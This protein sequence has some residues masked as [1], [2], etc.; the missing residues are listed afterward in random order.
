MTESVDGTIP[1]PAKKK[2]KTKSN[3]KSGDK[4]W[5]DFNIK[6]GKKAEAV[7][8]AV[9]KENLQKSEDRI[10][11]L[12]KERR[13]IMADLATIVPEG[14]KA[15]KRR[16]ADHKEKEDRNMD[17]EED[18]LASLLADSQESIFEEICEK[19]SQIESERKYLQHHRATVDR[20][21]AERETSP[22]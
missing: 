18:S 9:E 15:V 5:K 4:E 6:N 16:L 20:Y 21:I 3:S 19:E 12:Q 1:F 11:R 2:Q 7:T 13:E 22:E 10:A 17:S 14:R 8:F